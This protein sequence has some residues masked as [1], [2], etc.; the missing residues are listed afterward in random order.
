MS[1][2]P[3]ISQ[4]Y[5]KA[6]SA[7]VTEPEIELPLSSSSFDWDEHLFMTS[8]EA[9]SPHRYSV[10]L[11]G[12]LQ[13]DGP[14]S[15]T[16]KRTS[17]FDLVRH[18]SVASSI[19]PATLIRKS[20]IEFEKDFSVPAPPPPRESY[21]SLRPP[22]ARNASSGN[23]RKMSLSSDVARSTS[24]ARKATPLDKKSSRGHNKPTTANFA[25]TKPLPVHW[26]I[27]HDRAICVLDARGYN[28]SQSVRKL[29]RAFPELMGCV[30]TPKMID[31]RLLTLDQIVEIDY[32]RIGLEVSTQD[33]DCSQTSDCITSK[34]NVK[35]TE[36]D[37]SYVSFANAQT[38]CHSPDSARGSKY[39]AVLG[40][41]PSA[42]D[43]T[44][45]SKISRPMSMIEERPGSTA[46]VDGAA[47]L[48]PRVQEKDGNGKGKTGLRRT[49][50]QRWRARLALEG[51]R[52][53]GTGEAKET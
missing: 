14:L 34:E 3:H 39:K 15:V 6:L 41:A 17:S 47:T 10:D 24:A 31:R 26:T 40:L 48:I 9:V 13:A 5:F 27:A 52:E 22:A 25:E 29:R 33:M 21:S 51:K 4:L 46:S 20:P 44:F 32:W 11:A 38:A 12:Y 30:I 43:T 42:G 1:A 23:M 28:L 36:R 35:Q 50:T 18:P 7:P 49:G 8:Q 37:T 19:D 2:P 16:P 45:A 53:Q